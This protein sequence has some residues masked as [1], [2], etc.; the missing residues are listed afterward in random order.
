ME[1]LSDATRMYTTGCT[2]EC[3]PD[4][5]RSAINTEEL[6]ATVRLYK[7]NWRHSILR[8][9]DREYH[10]GN[11]QTPTRTQAATSEAPCML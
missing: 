5:I 9:W 11:R 2:V 3:V 8:V 4:D 10:G 1:V 6:A 7:T